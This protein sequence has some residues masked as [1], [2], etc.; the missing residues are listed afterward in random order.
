[1]RVVIAIASAGRPAVLGQTVR[2]MAGTL[3]P[4]ADE[5]L[6]CTPNKEDAADLPDLPNLRAMV[7]PRG[8]CA[9]RNELLKAATSADLVIFFDDDFYPARDFVERTVAL[10][11]SRNDV[12]VATGNVLLDGIHGP[13]VTP[14]EAKAFLAEVPPQP[15]AIGDTYNAYGCN[16]VVRMDL[17]RAH[18][19]S[20]DERLPLYAWL[21]DLDLSRQLARHG[22]SVR[23]TDMVGVHLGVKTG[24]SPGRRLGY[25][26]IANPW[27]LVRKGTMS[28]SKAWSHVSRNVLANLAGA[29]KGDALVDRRGRLS[30]NIGAIVDILRG[31]SSPDRVLSFQDPKANGT[32]SGTGGT[33]AKQ[34]GS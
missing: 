34:Q 29:V 22:R 14:D 10:F 1:M 30:G 9:Q 19:L 11:R 20:F 8:S 15:H 18:G 16:M 21:E 2:Y 32:V 26:Q 28:P 5:I 7:G 24:R 25:S 6:V 23:C 3:I 13:G 12:A 31:R 27:Y 17:I 4:A 33:S